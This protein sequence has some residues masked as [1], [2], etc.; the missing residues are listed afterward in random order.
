[1]RSDTGQDAFVSLRIVSVIRQLD[2]SLKLKIG[3]RINFSVMRP[4]NVN[5]H[6]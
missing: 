3:E 6:C 2:F 1:M 4:L 5:R